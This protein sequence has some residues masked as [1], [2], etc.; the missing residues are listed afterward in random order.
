VKQSNDFSGTGNDFAPQNTV[1]TPVANSTRLVW[2]QQPSD[3]EWDLAMSPAP[4]VSAVD[5]CGN[6][7]APSGVTLTPAAGTL[8]STGA[9]TS[10]TSVSFTT[11]KFTSYA[12]YGDTLTASATGFQSVTSNAFDVVQKLVPCPTGT[13][14]SSGNVTDTNKTTIASIVSATNTTGNSQHMTVSVTGTPPSTCGEPTGLTEPSFG[15]P[16]TLKLTGGLSKTVTLT[17]PKTYV[18]Q[19]PNNGTP[20]KDICLYNSSSAFVD[21]FGDAPSTTGLLPDCSSTVGAPCVISRGK[22]AGNEVI[23]FA[24]LGGDPSF[25]FR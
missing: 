14:C 25:N 6:A 21:K 16:A 13:S 7:V 23:T 20:F 15:T 17:L 24:L 9:T 3:T 10:G 5:A 4:A 1:A 2:T 8:A 19:L 12:F 22:N 18:N 11:L